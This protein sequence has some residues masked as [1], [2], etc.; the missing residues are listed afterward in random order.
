MKLTKN[1][2]NIYK[3]KIKQNKIKQRDKKNFKKLKIMNMNCARY[4]NEPVI[5]AL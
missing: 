1:E 3:N 4:I 2:Q 5:L